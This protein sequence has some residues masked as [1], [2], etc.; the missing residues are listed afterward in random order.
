MKVDKILTSL[1]DTVGIRCKTD[2][3]EHEM[4]KAELRAL[5]QQ[6][7]ESRAALEEQQEEIEAHAGQVRNEDTKGQVASVEKGGAVERNRGSDASP[8]V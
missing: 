6:Q 3:K 2:H 4:N 8:L 7:D 5:T 1:G